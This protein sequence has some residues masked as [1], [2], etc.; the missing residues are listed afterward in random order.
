MTPDENMEFRANFASEWMPEEEV[1]GNC[2]FS[3]GMHETRIWYRVLATAC[4]N[5]KGV[6]VVQ[7]KDED[8]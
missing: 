2:G 8:L 6:F 4:P 7:E 1:C 3:Y 5:D